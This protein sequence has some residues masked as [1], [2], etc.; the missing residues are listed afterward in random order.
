MKSA[1]IAT[2]TKC[3]VVRVELKINNLHSRRRCICST[4]M[5]VLL[6]WQTQHFIRT[7]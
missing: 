6:K 3:A 5:M 1:I 4:T 2:K 7:M